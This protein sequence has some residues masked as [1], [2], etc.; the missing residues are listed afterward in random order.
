MARIRSIKPEFWEDEQIAQLPYPCRLFYIGCWNFADDFG[1]LKNSPTL[2]KSWIFPY[3]DLKVSE[4]KKWIDMLIEAQKLVPLTY[5]RENYCIIRSFRKHQSTDKRYERSYLPKEQVI[6][7][8]EQTLREHAE[9][10]PWPRSELAETSPPERIGEDSIGEDSICSNDECVSEVEKEFERFWE[11]Y[12]K[13][14]NKVKVKA[15][16]LK[17][18]KADKA[19]IFET[20]PAY[21]KSTPDKTYRK[22]PLT[23]LNNQSWN[24]E[25]IQRNET[26][27]QS[28]K[29]W[30]TTDHSQYRNPNRSYPTIS[31]F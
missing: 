19:K 16:F 8:I 14:N 10:S 17:L 29:S 23:Y 31:D 27:Q 22:D 25:I 26:R 3:E 20:L 7:I 28:A 12:D 2:L 11:M 15:K 21:V 5:N 13:Q 18:S 24:D 6:S 30:P 4:V 1:I 9:T